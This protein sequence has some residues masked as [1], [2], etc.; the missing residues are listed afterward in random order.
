M[1][2]EVTAPTR[3]KVDSV[4]LGEL[5]SNEDRM[6]EDSDSPLGVLSKPG[7]VSISDLEQPTSV[8]P[9]FEGF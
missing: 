5:I 4:F 6:D 9:P 1:G 8:F 2:K 3:T 7:D